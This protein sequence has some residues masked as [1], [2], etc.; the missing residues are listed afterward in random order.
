MRK[1]RVTGL[2]GGVAGRSWLSS[3]ARSPAQQA[4]RPAFT[5]ET[6]KAP[7]E[8]DSA[9]PQITVSGGKTLLSWLERAGE[10]TALKFAERLPAGWS[11]PVVV[12]AERTPHH[13]LRGRA[14]GSRARGR[15]AGRALDR[16]ERAGS[17]GVRSE[18]FHV[19]RQRQDLVGARQSPPRRHEDAAR[20]RVVLQ[21]RY[22]SV[23]LVW[24]DGRQTF[25]GKGDM[26][27]RAATSIP[28]RRK[29]DMLVAP[30]VCD[31]CPTA[32]ANTADGPIVALP[33]PHGR[34][35]P[36]HLRDAA[37]WQRLVGAR[38]GAPATAGRS[39]AAR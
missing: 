26:T 11:A 28:V 18:D 22:T 2:A 14:L 4:S 37:R 8:G 25:G 20:V 34:R 19:A 30:R 9:S 6:L 27:L 39:T 1:I 24:L 21:L 16:D 36:R 23:G 29:S 33:R 13:Q 35:D 7:S 10:K 38:S 12:M 31:C 15:I 5:I 17:G 3:R 32:A